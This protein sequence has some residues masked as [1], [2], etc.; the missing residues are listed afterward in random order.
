M[1]WQSLKYEGRRKVATDKSYALL[2]YS[3][4]AIAA[5]YVIAQSSIKLSSHFLFDKLTGEKLVRIGTNFRAEQTPILSSPLLI[6]WMYQLLE[7]I[8]VIRLLREVF[9][10]LYQG[11]WRGRDVIAK[12]TFWSGWKRR[13]N[14]K[15]AVSYNETLIKLSLKK[16]R[17][18]RSRDISIFIWRKKIK[19][20]I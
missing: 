8:H 1:A 14:N 2:V 4:N 12:W 17:K 20:L 9:L 5:K 11:T 15:V 7:D 16:N 19:A 10:L 3:C 18:G 13:K 6:R